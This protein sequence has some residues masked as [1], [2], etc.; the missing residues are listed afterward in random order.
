MGKHPDAL[1]RSL[2]K[3]KV[4]AVD[5]ARADG[6][7]VRAAGLELERGIK[8]EL[9]KPGTGAFY[10]NHQASAPGEPPAVDTGALRNS[11][12][13]EVTGNVLRVGVAMPYGPFLEFGT[14]TEGGFIEPRPFMRPA[15]EAVRERMTGVVVSGVRKGLR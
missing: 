4:Q 6:A 2:G 5:I 9:S 7:T 3:L 1:S 10:G 8:L 15:L 12:G 13:Q 14:I 11:V